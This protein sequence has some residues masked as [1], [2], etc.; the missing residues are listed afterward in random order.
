M[1]NWI[2]ERLRGILGDSLREITAHH[3][4]HLLDEDATERDDLEF[5]REPW[6]KRK[7]QR[8]DRIDPNTELAR[9]L[10]QFANAGG[11]LLIIGA[12]E[13]ATD[14]RQL[15]EFRPLQSGAELS[16]RIENVASRQ[17]FPR[18]EFAVHTVRY[19]SGEIV[20]VS[21]PPSDK[22]PHG[23]Q[24]KNTPCYTF[25]ARGIRTRHYLHEN[26]VAEQYRMRFGRQE[27][28]L[29]HLNWVLDA[30]RQVAKATPGPM[31]RE[32]R[33]AKLVV[34]S[35]PRV[36]GKLEINRDVLSEYAA[37]IKDAG[38][39]MP[40]V[41]R[42]LN[43]REALP[44]F[45][46][47]RF[48][49]RPERQDPS[50]AAQ[51]DIHAASLNIEGSGWMV[52]DITSYVAS[53]HQHN[54]QVPMGTAVAY[55]LNLVRFLPVG[56]RLLAEH[57]KRAG[58]SDDLHFAAQ[59]VGSGSDDVGVALALRPTRW[60]TSPR[61]VRIASNS[62]ATYRSFSGS[63]LS[64]SMQD[65]L[66]ATYELGRDIVQGFEIME[67]PE[68][69]GAGELVSSGIPRKVHRDF[70]LWARQNHVGVVEHS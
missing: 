33:G 9:D 64:E 52:F 41:R 30:G 50:L 43:W 14:P 17:I 68:I 6:S 46:A 11:G 26:E 18:I 32:R 13:S 55:T 22:K 49:A 45:E 34:A 67:P 24:E 58:A 1:K 10:A 28:Q 27:D 65:L 15:M 38:V 19:G 3:L 62:L 2:P 39:W 63:I 5:K 12:V 57:G 35:L 44:G 40:P 4:D 56:L 51:T 59:L 42:Y 60:Y 8:K 48:G 16:E 69:T 7:T 23:V 20:L 70:I 37:W 66:S 54:S 31:W 53:S 25:P 29:D 47:I 36:F 21:V 61:Y